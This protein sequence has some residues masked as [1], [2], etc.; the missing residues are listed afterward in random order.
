LLREDSRGAH[1]RE[2]FPQAGELESS[3][4]TVARMTAQGLVLERE[5]VRFE[6][7]RPG[8][9]ILDEEPAAAH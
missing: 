9:T 8:Q 7:V 3:S 1:F 5:P 4:F 2:D 6:R